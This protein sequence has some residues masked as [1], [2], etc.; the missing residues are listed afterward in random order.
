[1]KL[2][3][4]HTALLAAVLFTLLVPFNAFSQDSR[5]GLDAENAVKD[6]TKQDQDI[7][8]GSENFENRSNLKNTTSSTASE[9]VVVREAEIKKP[10]PKAIDKPQ[11]DSEKAQKQ[12]EDPLSF[13]FLYYIIEKFKFTDI[14][15]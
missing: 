14:V 9:T 13:N 12:E 1:M 2:K 10:A 3:T 11:K 6:P 5:A 7:P 8:I 15:E 4:C